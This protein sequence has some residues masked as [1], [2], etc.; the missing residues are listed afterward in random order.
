MKRETKRFALVF[1]LALLVLILLIASS[2]KGVAADEEDLNV[3]VVGLDK[4]GNQ[5]VRSIPAAVYTK[6][7][8][9]AFSAVHRSMLPVLADRVEP[10]RG[11][12]AWRL[13]TLGVGLGLAGTIG[14]GPL[15]SA[16]AAAKL[17][18]V[19]TNSANP[20]FPD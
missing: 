16:T 2:G 20:T 18:L 6:S 15:I 10:A 1:G 4:A 14:L 13:R 9:A 5:V 11:R 7:M 3:A 17:R 12:P 19:F 8:T